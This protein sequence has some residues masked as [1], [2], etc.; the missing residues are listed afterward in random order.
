MVYWAMFLAQRKRFYRFSLVSS[1]Q[2]DKNMPI[3]QSK[4]F[5]L[6]ADKV[7][8]GANEAQAVSPTHIKST[9]K[10]PASASFSRLITFKLSINEKDNEMRSGQ[11]HWLVIGD[12]HESPMIT[13]GEKP[14]PQPPKPTTFLP[15]NYTYTFRVDMRSKSVV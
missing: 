5:T 9:Y 7:I 14:S 8:Q 1:C 11:D 4:A 10:S 13:F 15:A 2:T 6:Y 3:Y 12:E